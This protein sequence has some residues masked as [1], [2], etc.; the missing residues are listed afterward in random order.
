MMLERCCRG[1]WGLMEAVGLPGSRG[2][3]GKGFMMVDG[4][5]GKGEN[6]GGKIT[7]YLKV[8]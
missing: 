1:F 5:G 4:R 3:G 6:G 2:G 7:D 8:Q